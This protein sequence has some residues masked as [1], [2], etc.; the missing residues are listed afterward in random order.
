ME[1]WSLISMLVAVVA[2]GNMALAQLKVDQQG[3]V[4]IGVTQPNARL[5]V[6][7]YLGFTVWNVDSFIKTGDKGI[8]LNNGHDIEWLESSFGSGYGHRLYSRD[9][10]DGTGTTQLVLQGRRNSPDWSQ[11]LTI[12]NDG[13][14]GIGTAGS[15]LYLDGSGLWSGNNWS[16]VRLIASKI[17]TNTARL[18]TNGSVVQIPET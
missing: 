16:N 10:M 15:S 5:D 8:L 17:D 9:L 6:N 3:K 13:K 14:V 11:L 12:G 2:G 1:K 4:G 18:T 7:G